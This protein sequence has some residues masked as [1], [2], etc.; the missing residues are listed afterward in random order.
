MLD[1]LKWIGSIIAAIV[2][3]TILGSIVAAASGVMLILAL[4][5]GAVFLIAVIAV[6]IRSS[7]SDGD[8]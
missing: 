7:M 4:V 2:I 3:F 6:S 1:A 5:S 8:Y